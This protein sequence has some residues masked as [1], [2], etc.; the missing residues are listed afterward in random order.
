MGLNL[1]RN[2]EKINLIKKSEDINEKKN[3]LKMDVKDIGKYLEEKF[4]S[5]INKITKKEKKRKVVAFDIGTTSI[6]IVEGVYYNGKLSIEKCLKVSTPQNSMDEGQIINIDALYSVINDTLIKNDIKAKYGICT[7]NPSSIINR[8]ISIPKVKEEEIETVVRY[9]IQQ[10]FPINLDECILQALI[11]G[12]RKD[13]FDEKEKL[14]LRAVVYFKETALEYYKLLEKLNLKP[15]AL[16]VNFNAVNKFVNLTELNEIENSSDNAVAL[17]DMG[18]DFI[19]VNIYKGRNLDFTRK[20]KA[21]GKDIDE[22]LVFRGMV[23]Q[24][25]AYD[26]KINK[27]DLNDSINLNTETTIVEETIDEWIEKIE[28]VIKFYKNQEVGNSISRIIIYGGSSKIS[29]IERYMS[30][31]LGIEVMTLENVNNVNFKIEYK[32]ES[33]LKDYVNA[34]GSIIRL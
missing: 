33:E 20:I 13:E 11:L 29:G 4:Q 18:A 6:K 17:L 30:E 21:G 1:D 32:N 25:Q 22:N 12:E 15:Y 14:D 24:E 27:I 5:H 16:D 19:D 31:K 2:N 7:T 9:E 3:I 28:M 26:I 10:Y 34:I 8:E 23:T